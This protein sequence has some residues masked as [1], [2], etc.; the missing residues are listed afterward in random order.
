MN[1]SK[2]KKRKANIMW[3]TFNSYMFIKRYTVDNCFT[4][5]DWYFN[6]WVIKFIDTTFNI[7]LVDLLWSWGLISTK[8]Q[9][10]PVWC[11]NINPSLCFATLWVCLKVDHI[12]FEHGNVKAM[13][14]IDLM[15]WL[16]LALF[17]ATAFSVLRT[18]F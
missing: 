1:W 17:V 14:W 10:G 4:V 3:L 15:H 8:G 2:Q 16:Q 9:C 5:W 12:N 18:K 7:G 13:P 11:C 6:I